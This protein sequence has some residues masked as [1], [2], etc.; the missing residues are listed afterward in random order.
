MGDYLTPQVVEY[1]KIPKY[2]PLCEIL[3]GLIVARLFFTEEGC[4]VS[5]SDSTNYNS[6][7]PFLIIQKFQKYVSP[8]TVLEIFYSLK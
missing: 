3:V 7:H 8:L 2:G 4:Q 6:K 1:A 5:N